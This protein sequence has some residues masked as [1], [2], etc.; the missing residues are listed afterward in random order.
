LTGKLHVVG[1][2]IGN[3]GDMTPRALDVLSAVELIACED[4]R[5]TRSLLR[6]L[7]VAAPALIV[8]NE[9]TEVEACARIVSVLAG[10]AEVALVSDAG[11]P[12]VSDPGARLVR[13]V[14]DA[15]I[16]AV[17]VPGPSAVIA[18][19]VLSGLVD[20]R[21]VFDGFLPRKGSSRKAAIGDLVGERRTVVLFEAPHRIV[22]TLADLS[23]VLGADRPAVLCRELT[24]RYEEVVR[25]TLGSLLAH[26]SEATPKGEMVLVLG[27]A[28]PPADPEAA[29]IEAAVR[30]ALDNGAS[31]RDAASA[32]A[33][34]L[35][36]GRRDVYE[37]ASRLAQQD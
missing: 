7:G 3:L 12:A 26:V 13:A 17:V 35:G 28:A 33:S 27:G 22:R 4:T 5:Q 2:P 30:A 8:V 34:A 6:L 31:A 1:T 25:G 23:A 32:V 29:D 37:L 15:G 9:H 20:T 10:G 19:L 21:F 16:E 36:V 18:A 24:K 14:T 11:M